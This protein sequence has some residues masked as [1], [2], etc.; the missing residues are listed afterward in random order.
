[1]A[2]PTVMTRYGFTVLS[3]TV[4]GRGIRHGA[5]P[6]SRLV[7]LVGLPQPTL[8]TPKVERLG[9]ASMKCCARD[10]NPNRDR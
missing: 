4:I 10:L 3:E 6:F 7:K 2:T 8:T 5:H 1:M 9:V